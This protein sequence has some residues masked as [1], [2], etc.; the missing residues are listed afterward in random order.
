MTGPLNKQPPKSSCLSPIKRGR[1]PMFSESMSASERK[2]KQR[3][4]QDARIMDRPASEW[5]ES[6]CLRIMTTKRFQPFYE[7]AWRR[8]GQ[9]KHYP[10]QD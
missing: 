3:R 10:P 2:A 8:I 9:I 4:E 1:K 5:T 6:D 7:F